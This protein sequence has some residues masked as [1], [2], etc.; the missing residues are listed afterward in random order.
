MDPPFPLLQK[1]ASRLKAQPNCRSL[2]SLYFDHG[3][4]Y[5]PGQT[6]RSNVPQVRF[7]WY[8]AFAFPPTAAAVA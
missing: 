3:H 1:V 5:A 8:S 7:R 6:T 4:A 2:G